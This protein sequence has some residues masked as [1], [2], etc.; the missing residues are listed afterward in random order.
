MAEQSGEQRITDEVAAKLLSFMM[1]DVDPEIIQLVLGCATWGTAGG[2]ADD[3]DGAGEAQAARLRGLVE[4][5]TLVRD[6]GID[7]ARLDAIL[8][9]NRT[10]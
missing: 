8:G 9:L 3:Q 7:H 10:R 5:L 2:H 1:P 6:S 4:L